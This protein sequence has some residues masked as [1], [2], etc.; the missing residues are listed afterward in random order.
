[1]VIDRPL[2]RVSIKS[3]VLISAGLS[4]LFAQGNLSVS[5]VLV[6]LS[7]VLAGADYLL[8][9]R[10]T[11]L[12]LERITGILE[13]GYHCCNFSQDS[14]VRTTI[15]TASR[16][17]GEVLRQLGRYYPT[18]KYSSFR[19]GLSTSK[20]IIGLCFRNQ[21]RCLEVIKQE[22]SFKAHLVTKWGFTKEEADQVK[23]RRSYLAIPIIDALGKTLGVAYFDSM[24]EDTF[25]PE[26][27]DILT[28]G[29]VPLSKWV[30]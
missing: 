5:V 7:V 19:R 14:D 11:T 12:V 4:G 20:G 2:F 25:S 13:A 3:L 17:R 18:N 1:M 16:H 28:R 10:I 29:C 22:S 15:F 27:I 21:E 23:T 8:S 26:A 24:K 9:E 6:S 30:R